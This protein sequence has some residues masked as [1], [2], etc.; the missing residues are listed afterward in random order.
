MVTIR[1]VIS[2]A[3]CPNVTIR[4]LGDDGIAR[5]TQVLVV[6]DVVESVRLMEADEAGFIARWREFVRLVRHGILPLHGGRFRKSLGDGLLLEFEEALHAL[7][8]ASA[9]M[10]AARR[11]NQPGRDDLD[12]HLRV[13][14]HLARYVADDLDIYGAGV[15]LA[16]RLA[17]T[18]QPGEILMSEQVR[19]RLPAAERQQLEDLGVR[20]LRHVRQPTRVWRVPGPADPGTARRQLDPDELLLLAADAA[21]PGLF[22][23]EPAA[24]AA[25]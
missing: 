15:N 21:P 16:A 3:S 11:F 9:L 20:S 25:A 6:L 13:G 1:A 8:A 10:Q 14:L 2:P 22:T 12:M 24:F 4:C 18:A 7:H 23:S 17:Q 5:L 19:D